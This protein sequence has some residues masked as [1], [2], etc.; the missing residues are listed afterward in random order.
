MNR[1]VRSSPRCG[2]RSCR[3]APGGTLRRGSGPWRAASGAPHCLLQGD[4]EAGSR[5]GTPKPGLTLVPCCSRLWRQARRT[6]PAERRAAGLEEPSPSSEPWRCDRNG[7]RLG[8]VPRQ[9]RL[10]PAASEGFTRPTCS[11]TERSVQRPQSALYC[12]WQTVP[13]L[14]QPSRHGA[15]EKQNRKWSCTTLIYL[16]LGTKV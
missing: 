6:Q 11:S 9:V 2:C 16:R 10:K 8:A 15:K 12:A 14:P 13:C 5:S 7:F 1:S 3:A 4:T